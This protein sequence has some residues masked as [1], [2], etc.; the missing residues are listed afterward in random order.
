MKM[1]FN[2]NKIILALLF[3]SQL[4]FAQSSGV[5]ID[6]V[7][8]VIGN[9]IILQSDIDRDFE[10][11][12]QSGQSFPDKCSFLNNM[13]VQKMVLNQAK[14]DTLV[15][16]SDDRIKARVN[17][18]LEDF[19][20]RATD[21]QLFQ[22]YG[23][24]TIPELQNELE[25]IVKENALTES[26]KGLIEDGV[27]AS[28]E[29]VKNFFEKNK[30]ELPRINEEVELAHIIIYPEIT[31]EHKQQIIDSLQQIK[32]EIEQ[33]E[34]FATKAKLFSEDPGSANE[35]GLY[36]NIRRGK[37]VPEFDAVAFNLEEGQISDPVETEF[38]FHII[39]LDKRLGQ[40]IDV[41]HILITP[42]PTAE[43]IAAAKAKLEK[44]R[45]DIK[46]GKMTFKEAA[47]QNS[48]DKYT[49]FNGGVL[50]NPQTGED[51]FE[52]SGL[53]YDQIY[54]LAGLKKGDISDVFE[55]EYRNKKVLSILQLKDI[56]PAHQISLSTDYTRIKNYTLQ[57]KKQEKLYS[58]IRQNLGN[59]YVK[60]GKDYQ[61]C[62]FDFN[63]LKK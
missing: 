30:S 10:I 9:E 51:R 3:V 5:K 55:S 19:R 41:R 54:A 62:N 40:A 52:R 43:E 49:R 59:T 28:P 7:E 57:Q 26:K 17:G 24:K 44:I 31:E 15:S 27:D 20:S 48:V 36:K 42:K 8:A 39:Q 50:T 58:W 56:I 12:K 60:I 46:L 6:G 4:G 47:Y 1:K 37:F 61:N 29:D 34:S 21:E 22:M 16:V 25:I 33:G 35:G 13:L 2:V 38:G 14:N 63:W 45:E 32:K 53:P 23:V 18:I 11:A